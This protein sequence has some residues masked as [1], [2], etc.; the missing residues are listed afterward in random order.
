MGIFEACCSGCKRQ[1]SIQNQRIE[2]F[3][4]HVC[5]A[6]S[7]KT[8]ID[9]PV[10]FAELSSCRHNIFHIVNEQY[11][12]IYTQKPSCSD[13]SCEQAVMAIS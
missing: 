13:V 8:R 11:V 4:T 2:M 9:Y 1:V 12:A 10:S 6:W 5:S 3:L 7:T